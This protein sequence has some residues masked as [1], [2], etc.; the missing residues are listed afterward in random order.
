[1]YLIRNCSW[2][3]HTVM[4]YDVEIGEQT[5]RWFSCLKLEKT[6]SIFFTFKV[7]V[8]HTNKFH[9][10][11]FA[12][13]LWMYWIPNFRVLYYIFKVLSYANI[14]TCMFK[15]KEYAY[16]E[17]LKFMYVSKLCYPTKCCVLCIHSL[18]LSLKHNEEKT[19][20]FAVW[21]T[22]PFHIHIYSIALT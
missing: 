15:G 19:M 14:K 11:N 22:L 4:I 6:K 17:V 20:L 8:W 12:F 16:G 13:S 9:N 2:Q 1:M 7:L 18:K 21:Q 5:K 3:I 10:T